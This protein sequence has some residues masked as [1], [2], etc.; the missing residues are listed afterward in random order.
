MR[1]FYYCILL[2]SGT[3]YDDISI[4]LYT[5]F[6]EPPLFLI[7]FLATYFFVH[8]NRKNTFLKSEKG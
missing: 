1:L 3:K 4:I 5:F 6:A 2:F 7:S 8:Y